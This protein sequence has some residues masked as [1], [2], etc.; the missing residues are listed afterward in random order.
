MIISHKYRFIFLKTSKTA[1]TSVEIAL[2]KYCG[3]TDIITPI[4]EKDEIVRTKLG[5]RSSQNYFVA[6]SKHS[7]RELLTCMVNKNSR[8]RYYNH[9]SA[10]KIRKYIGKKIWDSYFKFAIE[11]NPWDRFVSLYYWRRSKGTNLTISEFL[12]SNISKNLR[13]KGLELYSINDEI[14]VNKICLY[15]NLEEDLEQVRLHLGIPG[16][17]VLPKVKSTFRKDK[18]SYREILDESQKEKIRE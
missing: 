16:K 18:K 2:S 6:Y 4:S 17:L 8:L 13:K 1:G 12:D 14:A 15:E 9:I 7:F 10:E 5:Y 11:R 3:D